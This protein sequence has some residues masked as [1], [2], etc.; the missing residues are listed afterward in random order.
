MKRFA[1]GDAHGNYK[2]LQ[3]ALA[4]ANFD[5]D[6]DMLISVGDLADGYSQVPEIIDYVMNLKNFVWCLGNHDKW[7]QDWF[8]GKMDMKGVGI[9][10]KYNPVASVSG[11]DRAEG[12]YATGIHPDT[13][14][15]LSQGGRATFKAYM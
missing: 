5:P 7:T 1:I 2:G 12:N 4:R 14:L 11:W 3:Q 15:W 13:D 8:A 10:G 9:D 6:N